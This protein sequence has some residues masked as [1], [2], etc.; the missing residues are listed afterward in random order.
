MR[1]DECYQLGYIVRTHG[2]KGDVIASFDV[3]FPEEYQ[4]LESV[5][6][7]QGN[8]VPFFLSDI[9][10]NSQKIILH[11]ED[12]DSVDAAKELVGLEIYLPISELP[13]LSGKNQYYYHDLI[14]CTI[15]SG[16]KALGE[17]TS[18]YQPS[19]QFIAAVSYKG[20]EI[21]V[22]VDDKIFTEVDTDKK[23][24]NADL[25]DGLLDIYL[26]DTS[27]EN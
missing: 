17:I 27:N 14:G 25:P 21:L 5:F 24:I 12:I 3:D 16:G 6:L 22:P 13:K 23:T 26:E 1:I 11:F 18:I 15:Y 10:I 7:L 2:L 8:L 20:S 9:Q 19:S 4:N